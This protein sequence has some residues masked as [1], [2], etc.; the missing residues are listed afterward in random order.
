MR[1]TG[2][3]KEKINYIF[4]LCYDIDNILFTVRNKVNKLGHINNMPAIATLI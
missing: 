2:I 3:G 1:K 4:K